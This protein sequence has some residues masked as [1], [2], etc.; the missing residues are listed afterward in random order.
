[1]MVVA[2]GV[3][4]ASPPARGDMV[5]AQPIH[6][7]GAVEQGVPVE[8]LFVLKNTGRG[9]VRIERPQSSCGCTV[10]AA[11]GQLLNRDQ[12]TSVR[13]RLDTAA[14]AG[15]TTKTVTVRTSDPRT[16]AVLLVLRGVVLTDL[17]V[18][19]TPIYL[20][21]VFRGD[22]ARHELVVAPGRPGPTGY[23]VSSVETDSDAIRAYVV[24]GDTPGQQKVI[25]ELAADAPSGRFNDRVMI[26]TTSPRQPVITVPIF[27]NVVG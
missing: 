11:E 18:T 12:L 1:M 8:H 10:A 2:L 22:P 17:T 25:V 5:A 23:S 26:H 13:V 21:H 19:P 9:M 3:L 20:G 14:L 6:D 4:A 15:R 16:P 27:G 24:Q 7:F